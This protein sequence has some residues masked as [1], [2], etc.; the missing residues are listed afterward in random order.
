M[1]LD[2]PGNCNEG[3][4]YTVVSKSWGLPLTVQ[5]TENPVMGSPETGSLIFG[6]SPRKF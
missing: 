6:N 5:A 3:G 4:I 2:N 1:H